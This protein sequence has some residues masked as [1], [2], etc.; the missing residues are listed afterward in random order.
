[1][2]KGFAQ[3]L[4]FQGA[5]ILLNVLLQV[6]VPGPVLG[7]LLMLLYCLIF[8]PGPD[9]QQTSQALLGVLPLF[10]LPASAGIVDYGPLMRSAWLPISLALLA[11]L[12]VSFWITPY[13]FRMFMR[14]FGMRS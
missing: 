13:L 9:L 11:S 1:M 3:L 14:L 4:A 8:T 12:V 2:L 6:P 5:G 7:M 10:I